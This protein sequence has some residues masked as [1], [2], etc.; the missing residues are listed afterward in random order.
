M[1][2]KGQLSY[3]YIIV[4]GMVLL[5]AIP[6]FF[7][8]FRYLLGGFD[9]QMN[10]DLV[11]RVAQATETLTNLGGVGSKLEVPVRVAKVMQN[12]IDNNHILSIKT[13]N[14]QTYSAQAVAQNVKVGSEALKGD[15]FITVPLI[16][17]YLGTVVIGRQP[18]IVAI[19]PSNVDPYSSLCTT[20]TSI[21]PSESFRLLG[22]N[23]QA[24]SEIIMSKIQGSGTGCL[25]MT[26]CIIDS[27]CSQGQ[28]CENGICAHFNPTTTI[29]EGGL[30]MDVG[31]AGTGAGT[32]D[33]AVA[34]PDGKKSD[35]VSLQVSSQQISYC[36]N[37]IID[38][39]EECDPPAAS[40]LQCPDEDAGDYNECKSNCKCKN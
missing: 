9:N 5:L 1:N 34:N 35:C 39:G 16:N 23:F 37:S 20:T 7:S 8:F 32:Y 33:V 4:I 27:E 13:S 21:A 31:T 25:S 40:S 18:Q 36:G 15:G 29:S 19:C 24:D 26:P 30:I 28:T 38:E 11:V 6:F 12:A 22:A 14:G 10:A 2:K 3:E 17:T